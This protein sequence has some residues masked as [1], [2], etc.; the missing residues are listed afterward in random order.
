M[1]KISMVRIDY[2]LIHGQV[3]TKWV[4]QANADQIIIVNDELAQDEFMSSIY[5]MSAPPGIKV[6][7]FTHEQAQNSWQENNFGDGVVLLLYRSIKD[8][9][10]SFKN[11]LNFQTMNIGGIASEP[12]KKEII[13]QVSMSKE[14]YTELCWLHEKNVDI[15]VQVLPNEPRIEFSDLGKRFS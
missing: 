5:K 8:A 1:A 15:N 7:V 12:G 9:V 11:G 13:G 4:K 14:E 2:R 10:E 3:I 6:L